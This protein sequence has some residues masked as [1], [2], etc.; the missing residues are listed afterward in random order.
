MEKTFYD[1]FAGIGGFRLVLEEFGW[2]CVGGCE[3]NAGGIKKREIY[4]RHFGYFPS[5]MDIRQVKEIP[6]CT[7]FCGGFPCPTFSIAGKRLGFE[8]PRGELVFEIFRLVR[9]KRPRLLFLENVK[10]LLSHDRGRTFAVILAKMDE[11]GYDVEWQVLN[12]KYWLPQSRE[13]VYIIGHLRGKSRTKVFPLGEGDHISVETC[14]ATQETRERLRG[15]YTRT[16]DKHHGKGGARTMIMLS[17][18]KANLKQRIQ[19]RNTTWTL[20]ID[21]NKMGIFEGAKIRKLTPLEC[22]RLQGF[23]DNYTMYDYSGNRISDNNRYACIGD[24]VTL[25][26]IRAIAKRLELCI[27]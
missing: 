21:G 14:R 15:A 10:G 8:D 1:G 20:T 24:S 9:Q 6:D 11:L 26:V 23:P 18:T 25:P 13:R 4:K 19:E 27:D 16:I 12:S 17:H 3:N 5:D 22:E 2:K 7:M